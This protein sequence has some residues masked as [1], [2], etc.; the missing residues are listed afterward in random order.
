MRDPYVRVPGDPVPW[1]LAKRSKTGAA[2]IPDRQAHHADHFRVAWAKLELDVLPKGAAVRLFCL[3]VV[4][5]PKGHYGTGRNAELLKDWAPKHPTGRPDLS[6]LVK[7]VEDAL[8]GAAWHDDDQVVSIDAAKR[9]AAL[10]EVPHTIVRLMV[11]SP[12]DARLDRP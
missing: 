3:F 9:Y 12:G 7:L 8:T 2:Y 11:D 4:K 6:N 1:G 10:E 5:R